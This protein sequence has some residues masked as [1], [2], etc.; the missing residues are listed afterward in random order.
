MDTASPKI[1]AVILNIADTGGLVA[2]LLSLDK[3]VY[4]NLEI[5]V[6]HNGPYKGEFE[7]EIRRAS[8]KIAEVV[9]TESNA[10]F[11][12][13]NNTGI[14]RALKNGAEYVLLLNDDTAAAPDFIDCLVSEARKDPARDM[15]G[16]RIN[17]FSDPE[18]IWF[19]GA[20][21][22][23]EECVFSFP[24]ADQ[25][26]A[27]YGQQEPAETAYVTGCALLASRKLI[28]TVG[29]LDERYFLYWEDADWGLRALKAGFAPLVVPA[30]KVLHK[31]SSS[32]GGNDSPL[33]I[34]HKTR[35]QLLFAASHAPYARGRL[36]YGFIKDISWLLLKSGQ[37]GRFLK[38]KAYA[39]GAADY[40][41]GRG[42]PGPS[43]L[44]P[45]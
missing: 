24:G 44:W 42:G 36:I 45:K 33:K 9:F 25:L 23:R 38:A 21:F 18:K 13:G 12:A 14:K 37:T 43:W 41:L 10:G 4:P 39:A 2:C 19:S 35:G 31:V 34:Y 6:V 5:I 7:N 20:I 28:E 17:Y 40:L 26:E 15:L 3:T 8:A 1:C 29:M 30:A 22:N 11:A 32:A 27:V 16:P